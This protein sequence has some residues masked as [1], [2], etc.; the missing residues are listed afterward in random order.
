LAADWDAAAAALAAADR[1]A[2]AA[3]C[4]ASADWLAA[5][6]ASACAALLASAAGDSELVA[7]DCSLAAAG[8]AFDADLELGSAATS[9]TKAATA[10][11]IQNRRDR[12]PA[13]AT[14]PERFNADPHRVK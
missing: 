14:M 1:E 6:A 5:A 2:S 3:D 7:D 9:S 11:S 8:R 4:N 10:V 13:H 12:R